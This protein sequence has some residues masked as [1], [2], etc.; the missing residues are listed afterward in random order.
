MKTSTLQGDLYKKNKRLNKN[1]TRKLNLNPHQ[2]SPTLRSTYK[3]PTK[4]NGA[5]RERLENISIV[6]PK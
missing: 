5:Q 2:V 6:C 1:T 3:E 4:L